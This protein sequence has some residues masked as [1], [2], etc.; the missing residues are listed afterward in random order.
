MLIAIQMLSFDINIRRLKYI[1][2]VNDNRNV[3]VTISERVLGFRFKNVRSNFCVRV[4]SHVAFKSKHGAFR[5][6]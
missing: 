5:E 6:N 3:T 4:V 2:I 1:I